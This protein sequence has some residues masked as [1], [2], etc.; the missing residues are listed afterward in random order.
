MVDPEPYLRD[1]H[2]GLHLQVD[3]AFDPV[4]LL[5]DVDRDRPQFPQIRSEYLD[6][7]LGPHAREDM[8]KAV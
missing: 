5:L 7:H 6:H 4:H 2:L 3:H 8:V 1:L